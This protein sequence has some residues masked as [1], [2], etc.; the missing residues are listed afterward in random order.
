MPTYG[1]KCVE[2]DHTF[3]VFQKVTDDPIK[4]CEKCKGSVRK[5]LYP[6]GIMFKGPGFHVTDY[7]KPDS[8]GGNG[9]TETKSE[10]K[11]ESK[12]EKTPAKE[13]AKA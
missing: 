5:L 7:R 13:P 3:E 4:E 9:H 1:Y 11:A 2:C 12:T 8:K 10:P 6:V